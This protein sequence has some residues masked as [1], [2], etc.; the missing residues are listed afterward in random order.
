MA[1]M[2]IRGVQRMAN[3]FNMSSTEA[4]FEA[5]SAYGE[6]LDYMLKDY[7]NKHRRSR[8]FRFYFNAR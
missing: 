8:W 4:T 7:H 5:I 6:T 2:G 3:E 1:G